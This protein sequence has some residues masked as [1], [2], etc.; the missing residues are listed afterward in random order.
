[1]TELT[2]R[3]RISKMFVAVHK[4]YPRWIDMMNLLRV[5]ALKHPETFKGKL[6]NSLDTRIKPVVDEVNEWIQQGILRHV[7]SE[8]LAIMLAGI[9]EYACYYIY[10]G[11]FSQEPYEIGDQMVDILFR[12][13]LMPKGEEKESMNHQLFVQTS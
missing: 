2:V 7:N 11:K 3:Q 4:A 13:V 9:A 1:M 6:Q 12:G 5:A 10:E 8:I